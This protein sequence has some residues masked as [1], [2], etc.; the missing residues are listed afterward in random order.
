[1]HKVCI[2]LFRAQRALFSTEDGSRPATA[3][4]SARMEEGTP[5]A[6]WVCH[7]QRHCQRLATRPLARRLAM[8]PPPCCCLAIPSSHLKIWRGP[9]VWP[10]GG[11]GAANVVELIQLGRGKHAATRGKQLCQAQAFAC[12]VPPTTIQIPMQDV[13]LEWQTS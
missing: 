13:R 4:L 11:K 8:P 10:L 1:M 5:A 3:A 6:N 7:C 2:L 12:A 9:C